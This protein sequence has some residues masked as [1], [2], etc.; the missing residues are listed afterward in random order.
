VFDAD[1]PPFYDDCVPDLGTPGPVLDGCGT[2]LTTQGAGVGYR[3]PPSAALPTPPINPIYQGV[4]S[5][6][7]GGP[8]PGVFIGAP[9][10]LSDQ[11]VMQFSFD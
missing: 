2:S 9:V 8:V 1:L 7:P 11:G 4:A 6:P 3:V 5:A 10:Y